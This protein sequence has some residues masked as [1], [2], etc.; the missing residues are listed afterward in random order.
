MR[1]D[2]PAS[3]VRNRAEARVPSL[4]LDRRVSGWNLVDG[5]LRDQLGDEATLLV[6]LRHFG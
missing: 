4:L 2:Q 5:S 1:R 6:F 3:A